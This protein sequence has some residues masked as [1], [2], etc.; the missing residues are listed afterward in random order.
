MRACLCAG[1]GA[2]AGAEGGAGSAA[3]PPCLS[4]REMLVT[5][6][7]EANHGVAIDAARFLN[8]CPIIALTADHEAPA[9]PGLGPGLG[10]GPEERAHPQE[11]LLR[12][13]AAFG[14][15]AALF[16]LETLLHRLNAPETGEKCQNKEDEEMWKGEM[17]VNAEELRAV[18]AGSGE[19]GPEARKML[20]GA[21]P[22]HGHGH[23]HGAGAGAGG[24]AGAI[25]WMVL[26]GDGVHNLTDGLAIG[27]AFC[28]DPCSSWLK[29]GRSA[30]D[31]SEYHRRTNRTFSETKDEK[32]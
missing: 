4:P 21:E 7:L 27:A 31:S 10:P 2:A 8:L 15:M 24:G 18:G 3:P 16:A 20:G 30:E 6:G 5:F 9:G 29:E 17:M 25:V 19:G 26:L 32:C 11:G 12:A 22:G 13:A 23:S 1:E 14:T 28:D